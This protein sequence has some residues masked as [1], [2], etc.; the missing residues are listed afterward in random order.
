M[1]VT[2]QDYY[3]ILGVSRTAAQSDIQKAYRKLAVKYHPDKNPGNRDAEEKFKK[4]G[5]AYEVLKDPEKRKRYDALGADWK[6]GQEFR[7]P[8]GWEQAFG[9]GMGGGAGRGGRTYRHA[10]GGGAGPGGMGGFSDFFDMLFGQAAGGGMGGGGFRA[11]AGRGGAGP[12]GMGFN[13]EDL[14]EEEPEAGGAQEAEIT[15]SLE[16]AYHGAAKSFRMETVEP[17]ARGRMQPHSR[18][19]QVKIPPGTTDGSTIRLAGQGGGHLLLHVHIA[20]HPHFKVDGYDLRTELCVSPW[21]AALGTG[22]PLHTLDGE[23]R[24]RIPPGTG[25]GKVLRL[26]G[27]GLPRTR[28]LERGD[29][30]VEIRIVVPET[31]T[32]EEEAL[33]RKLAAVSHFKPRNKG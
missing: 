33:F 24:L 29:L 2:F 5:E 17:D 26:R 3:Q 1:P 12:G 7:P 9:G 27:K 14:M 11:R 20:A 30:L 16:D 19:Y 21:E 18:T 32:A 15:I 13:F 6:G 10:P 28:G 22:V 25:S 4:I 8:P 31:L 23:G